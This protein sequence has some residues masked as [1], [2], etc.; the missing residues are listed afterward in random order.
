MSKYIYILITLFFILY[1]TSHAQFLP[2]KNNY[3]RT[4]ANTAEIFTNI[5]RE[6]QK[7]I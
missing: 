2:I 3:Y 4:V 6:D 5:S 7:K 1:T